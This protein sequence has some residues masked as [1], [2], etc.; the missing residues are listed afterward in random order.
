MS[1][2]DTFS[3]MLRKPVW[4]VAAC[5]LAGAVSYGAAQIVPALPFNLQNNTVADA[6]QVMANFNQILNSTNANAAKNGANS[7]IT[8]L[9]GLTTPLAPSVGGTT[10]FTGGTSGGTGN[11]QTVS[12][13]VPSTF[14]LATGTRVVFRAGNT[15]TAA[16]T[17]NVSGSG[18]KDVYRQTQVGIFPTVGGEVVQGSMIE[19]VYDGT[20]YQLVA[21]PAIVGQI[22]DYIGPAPANGWAIADG[23]CVSQTTYA[24]LFV[25]ASTTWGTCGA[26]QFALPDLQ[27]RVTVGKDGAARIS[28]SC[29]SSGVLATGCGAQSQTITQGHL[30]AL[31]LPDTLGISDTRTWATGAGA[32]SDSG[33]GAAAAGGFHTGVGGAIAV[34]TT[35]GSISKTG[36]VTTGGSG[37]ALPIVQPTLI[38]QKMIKL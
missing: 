32:L 26:G 8:A 2:W 35:G 31:T 13:V 34:T 38:V 36:N 17:L 22:A 30:P 19:A 18:V 25:L 4:L 21:A 9:L 23:T 7:D 12:P 27:G 20:Q 29:P 3:K 16:M 15:N 14:T 5:A 1:N 33:S 28:T 37:T 6:T 10:T 24:A 11:A